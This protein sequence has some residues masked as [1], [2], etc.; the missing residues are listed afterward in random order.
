V[1]QTDVY[2]LVTILLATTGAPAFLDD[3]DG[4]DVGTLQNMATRL[5]YHCIYMLDF[6]RSTQVYLPIYLNMLIN[7]EKP[8][9][10]SNAHFYYFSV[11]DVVNVH[12][13]TYG[14]VG[15]LLY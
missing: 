7:K 13:I 10:A 14:S 1:S 9:I 12:Y 2:E 5:N 3:E 6:Q 15:D 8:E 11:A 4:G